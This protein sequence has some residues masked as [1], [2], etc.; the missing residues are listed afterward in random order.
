MTDFADVRA[1][2]DYHRSACLC[3]VGA[4]DYLLTVAIAADGTETFMLARHDAIGDPSI[5]YRRDCPD[6]PHEQAD[7]LPLEFV[8]RVTISQRTHRCGRPTKA[9]RPCRIAVNR[10]GD[11]CCW[12]RSKADA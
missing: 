8:R 2:V 3:D 12:H 7:R 6:A 10:P 11:A 4:P 9:G 1:L 5:T